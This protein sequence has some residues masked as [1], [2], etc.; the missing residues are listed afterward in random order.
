[1]LSERR[2]ARGVTLIELMIGIAIVAILLSMGLPSFRTWI[3][4][5]KI[6]TAAE[7]VQN[8]LQI[9]RVQAVQ[10]NRGVQF[11]LRDDSAWTVC[12]QP[13]PPG[14]CPDPDDDTTIQSRFAQEGE[15]GSVIVAVS[16]GAVPVVFDPSGRAPG[17]AVVID[18]DSDVLPEDESRN[19]RVV[20]TA[21]GSI[22]MCDPNLADADPRACP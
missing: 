12:L 19:L 21:S 10:R 4:N 8:G 22:R 1:M 17:S 15:T 16:A 11:D 7:S 6:R 14:R 13:A 9:A 3:Q 18:F 20:V 5:S 2:S